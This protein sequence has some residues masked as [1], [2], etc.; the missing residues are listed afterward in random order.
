MA[1]GTVVALASAGVALVAA[2]SAGLAYTRAKKRAFEEDPGEFGLPAADEPKN[3]PLLGGGAD[4]EAYATSP[5][6]RLW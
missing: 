3:A 1:S 6:E 4:E 5:G 2:A